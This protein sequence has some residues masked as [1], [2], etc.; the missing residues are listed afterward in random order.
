MKNVKQYYKELGKLVY[1]VAIADGAIQDEE[2]E[3]LHEFV[4]KELA[5]KESTTDSSGMNQAFY[6]D[7]EFDEAEQNHLPIHDVIQGYKRFIQANHEPNDKVLIK[8]SMKLLEAVALAYS[9]EKEQQII[10]NVKNEING[11]SKNI[12]SEIE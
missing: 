4:A 7:F 1:A 9:K 6:V 10:D 8:N 3:K 12:L 11:I 2:R 5:D